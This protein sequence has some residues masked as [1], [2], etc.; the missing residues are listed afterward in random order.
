MENIVNWPH[1]KNRSS[2][3]NI[4]LVEYLNNQ[5]PANTSFSFLTESIHGISKFHVSLKNKNRELIRF[6][7]GRQ[8]IPQFNLAIDAVN[9]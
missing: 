9:A 4:D 8:K 6:G 5:E 7:K 3:K 1:L 2:W